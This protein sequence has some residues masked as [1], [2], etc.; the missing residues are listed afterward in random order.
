MFL[1]KPLLVVNEDTHDILSITIVVNISFS[2]GS[3][4]LLRI[5]RLVVNVA[6]IASFL[7]GSKLAINSGLRN[8]FGRHSS[9]IHQKIILRNSSRTT[10]SRMNFSFKNRLR[11]EVEAGDIEKRSGEEIYEAKLKRCEAR[12]TRETKLVK[13]AKEIVM[14]SNT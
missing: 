11:S 4:R 12:L 5:D 2:G 7:S 8:L 3:E 1:I 14:A 13:L 6:E 9:I 10:L